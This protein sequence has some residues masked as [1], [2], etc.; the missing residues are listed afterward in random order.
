MKKEKLK[1]SLKKDQAIF[2]AQNF[3]YKHFMC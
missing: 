1:D 3:Y 2:L